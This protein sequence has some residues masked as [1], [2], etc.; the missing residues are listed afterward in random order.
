M[1]RRDFLLSA[2]A[3]A[4][5]AIVGPHIPA[6][7]TPIAPKNVLTWAELRAAI[8]ELRASGVAG[9]LTAI[10]H[11]DTVLDLFSDEE[12]V[13][14]FQTSMAC[15]QEAVRRGVLGDA[16]GVTFIESMYAP[17]ELRLTA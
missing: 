3:A 7:T 12:V 4:G 9:P 13:Y 6:P 14:A 17:Q 1:N 10:I 5:V 2:L 16:L 15:D 11:P 8:S